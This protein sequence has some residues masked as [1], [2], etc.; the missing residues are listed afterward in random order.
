LKNN[1]FPL[2]SVRSVRDAWGLKAAR[3]GVMASGLFVVNVLFSPE[4]RAAGTNA[5]FLDGI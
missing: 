5:D 2:T 1:P 3:A 4:A